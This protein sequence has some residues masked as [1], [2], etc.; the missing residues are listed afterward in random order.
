[1]CVDSLSFIKYV[2]GERVARARGLLSCFASSPEHNVLNVAVRNFTNL[3]IVK[4]LMLNLCSQKKPSNTDMELS[5][6]QS[7]GQSVEPSKAVTG[8]KWEY[9]IY[10]DPEAEVEYGDKYFI[11]ED[12][13][14]TTL[15]QLVGVDEVIINVWVFKAPL[16]EAESSPR[17]LFHMFVVF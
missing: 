14:M 17:L 10:F 4:R 3:S 5:S 8:H 9:K 6:Y 16:M 7:N 2:I 11:K 12:D 13:L 1:M 15:K